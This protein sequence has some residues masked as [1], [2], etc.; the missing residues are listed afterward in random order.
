MVGWFIEAVA[1]RRTTYLVSYRFVCYGGVRDRV[2]TIFEIFY[3][4]WVEEGRDL[5]IWLLREHEKHRL[6]DLAI[7]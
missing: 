7:K 6:L 3:W 1:R 5:P 2:N 4:F